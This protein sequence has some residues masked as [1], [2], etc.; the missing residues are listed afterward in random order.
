MSFTRISALDAHARWK[1]APDTTVL[2]D[3][4]QPEEVRLA[5][6]SGALLI[7]MREVAARLS[8]ID[9][10]KE[11]LVLCHHGSRSMPVAA[12]LA[13]SGYARVSSV[14]GGIA[15]WSRDVDPSIPQY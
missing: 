5:S 6:V 14:D 2:L 3:V 4:R 13:R 12:F 7:P 9:P 10:A 11:V 15:A 8:E 1:A